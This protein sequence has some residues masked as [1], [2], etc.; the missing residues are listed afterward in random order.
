MLSRDN[1]DRARLSNE[2]IAK[3]AS[4]TWL[5]YRYFRRADT[6]EERYM[7]PRAWAIQS[8]SFT[9]MEW[10]SATVA[11]WV[12]AAFFSFTCGGGGEPLDAILSVAP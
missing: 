5:D 6:V 2:A 3:D 12:L 7:M 10:F 11:L 1:A 8:E 9:Y 4:V